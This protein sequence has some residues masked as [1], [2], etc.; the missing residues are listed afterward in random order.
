[1]PASCRSRATA[2]IVPTLRRG[3]AAPDAPA[4]RIQIDAPLERHKPVPTPERGNHKTS[5]ISPKY[6]EKFVDSCSF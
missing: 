6:C 3:N 2:I 4:S 5:I 1:M